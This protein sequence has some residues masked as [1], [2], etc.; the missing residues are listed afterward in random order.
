[1]VEVLVVRV[2]PVLITKMAVLEVQVEVQV[3]EEGRQLLQKAEDLELL[4]K[5]LMVEVLL[6]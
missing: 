5:V 4:I 1:M 3:E 2:L 6:E